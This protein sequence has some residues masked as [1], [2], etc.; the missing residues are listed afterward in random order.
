MQ[1]SKR[2]PAE[3][4]RARRSRALWLA[5]TLTLLTGQAMAA[6]RCWDAQRM[7]RYEDMLP[8]YIVRPHSAE[9]EYKL[10]MTAVGEGR[11]LIS[12]VETEMG[13]APV[14]VASFTTMIERAGPGQ[15]L[16]PRGL[17]FKLPVVLVPHEGDYE[18][19]VNYG[20]RN[21][22]P[23]AFRFN[24]AAGELGTLSVGPSAFGVTQ[25]DLIIDAASAKALLEGML[26]GGFSLDV[27]IDGEVHA[28]ATDTRGFF[29]F[30]SETI[31]P[32]MQRFAALEAQGLCE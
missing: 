29:K 20:F 22:L 23:V 19:A 5:T 1:G 8:N 21:G 14:Q 16:L 10:E 31:Y 26:A 25:R 27:L 4:K 24:G 3:A 2:L 15:P 28:T 11:T 6:E 17:V 9:I 7:S 32:Q 13:M 18:P 12:E 30:Y